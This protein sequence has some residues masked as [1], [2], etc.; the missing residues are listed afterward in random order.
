[1]T[2]IHITIPIELKN[3]F[4]AKCSEMGLSM[5][6]KTRELIRVFLGIKEED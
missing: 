5:D 1:M 6:S 4:K 2:K 3:L